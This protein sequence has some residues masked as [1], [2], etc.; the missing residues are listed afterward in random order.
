MF[1]A[2]F[3]IHIFLFTTADLPWIFINSYFFHISV[4]INV[5]FP[6]Q[7]Y[8]HFGF[9]QL[10]NNI[11]T[12]VHLLA[13]LLQLLA[14]VIHF[15]PSFLQFLYM[16][17]LYLSLVA[18]VKTMKLHKPALIKNIEQYL[19]CEWMKIKTLLHIIATYCIWKQTKSKSKAMHT[20]YLLREHHEWYRDEKNTT[21]RIFLHCIRKLTFSSCRILTDSPWIWA[22]EAS[23][24]LCCSWAFTFCNSS[25]LC[26]T[27]TCNDDEN[28]Y[29]YDCK[30]WMQWDFTS[31]YR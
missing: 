29:E 22:P 15:L 8:S 9:L 31:N 2:L 19:Y 6:I 7:I 21:Y 30:I 20:A 11:C 1:S 17:V 18:M 4:F 28:K 25:S 27:A 10:G 3:W 5:L 23:M 24:G 12:V 14:Q 26:L 13:C 16:Y